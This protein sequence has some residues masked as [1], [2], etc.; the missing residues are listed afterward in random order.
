MSIHRVVAVSND[1]GNTICASRQA[2]EGETDLLEDAML[3]IEELLCKEVRIER[4]DRG[5]A[6][7]FVSTKEVEV[8]TYQHGWDDEKSADADAA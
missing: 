6:Y 1:R 4:I 7:F 8:L 2:K 3:T 5:K